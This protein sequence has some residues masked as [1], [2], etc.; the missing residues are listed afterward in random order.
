MISSNASRRDT[1][2]PL[3]EDEAH[4]YW[5]RPSDLNPDRQQ[6]LLLWLSADERRAYE[7][8]RMPED[9]RAY[10]A[11]HVLVRKSLSNYSTFAEP[12]WAFSRSKNGR[13]ILADRHSDQNLYFN[14][15]HSRSLVACIVS[16]RQVC[17]VDVE[18]LRPIVDYRDIAARFFAPMEQGQL[19]QVD[20]ARSEALFLSLWTLK[21]ATLKATGD[22][23]LAPLHS[24]AFRVDEK[25]RVEL[26]AGSTL[27]LNPDE[28]SFFLE[29]SL[30]GHCLAA[31]VRRP[32]QGSF[33]FVLHPAL[34]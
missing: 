30:H 22:A 25:N 32:N 14:I 4:I 21:E 5:A 20:E 7:A 15:S 28:W 31:A 19:L 1:L 10:L 9:R 17:G 2:E 34:L 27:G 12:D 6:R 29:L 33:R 3:E 26:Q 23:L 13:P 18:P 8:L 11:A 24:V 16:R